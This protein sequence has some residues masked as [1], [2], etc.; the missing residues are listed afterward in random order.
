MRSTAAIAVGLSVDTS[1]AEVVKTNA[2][3]IREKM[4]RIR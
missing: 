2:T 3:Q 4:T 1:V